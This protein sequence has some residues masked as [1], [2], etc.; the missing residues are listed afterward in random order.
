LNA[1]HREEVLSVGC[2]RASGWRGSVREDTTNKGLM[3][4][5]FVDNLNIAVLVVSFFLP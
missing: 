3:F 2:R 1:V 4:S 5:L